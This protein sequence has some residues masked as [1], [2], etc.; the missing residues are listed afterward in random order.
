ME[1]ALNKSLLIILPNLTCFLDE[2]PHVI[3][4][5]LVLGKFRAGIPGKLPIGDAPATINTNLNGGQPPCAP[6]T[7][8]I[9]D[10]REFVSFAHGA[11]SVHGGT[12]AA[13]Y[14]RN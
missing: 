6:P 14:L 13:K 9:L 5:Y 2:N 3:L 4:V 1:R 12:A 10:Q 7:H 11:P 8:P